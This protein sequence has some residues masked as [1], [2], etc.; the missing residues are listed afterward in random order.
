MTTKISS[1]S[2]SGEPYLH[3]IFD[4]VTKMVLHNLYENDK[5]ARKYL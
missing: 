1:N 2:S 4:S 5:P 3:E